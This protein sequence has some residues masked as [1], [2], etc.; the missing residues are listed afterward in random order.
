MDIFIVCG[1]CIAACL[2]AKMLEQENCDIKMLVVLI[3][4][5]VVASQVIGKLSG[6]YDTLNG[7]LSKADIDG[8]YIKILLKA[9]GICLVTQLSCE[10]CKDCGENAIASQL[11]LF[12]RIS[13]LIISLPLYSSVISI[14]I[15]LMG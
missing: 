8:E 5:V 9:L 6:V 2:A 1:L 4:S 11:E 15:S 13:L 12:G 10:C 7:F 14:A 3:S